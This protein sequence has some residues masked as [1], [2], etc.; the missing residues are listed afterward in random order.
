MQL[1]LT[2]A[3]N[4]RLSGICW[5]ATESINFM[6][7]YNNKGQCLLPDVY[8]LL[9][10]RCTIISPY[11]AFDNV[12]WSLEVSKRTVLKTVDNKDWNREGCSARW[13]KSQWFSRIGDLLQ[14]ETLLLFWDCISTFLVCFT[15]KWHILNI[16]EQEYALTRSLV[17]L[18]PFSHNLNILANTSADRWGKYINWSLVISSNMCKH[19]SAKSR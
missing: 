15:A 13:L 3:T 11:N 14:V 19:V 7:Y 17:E 1:Q 4:S 9:T 18:I 6:A 8:R 2:L 10:S 16:E 12:H 5:L